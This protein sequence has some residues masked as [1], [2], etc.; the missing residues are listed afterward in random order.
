MI[1]HELLTDDGFLK[2]ATLVQLKQLAGPKGE[3]HALI[4]FLK[5]VVDFGGDQGGKLALGKRFIFVKRLSTD[6]Q[7]SFQE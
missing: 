1:N 3:N 4:V 5:V 6:E 7:I 2:L